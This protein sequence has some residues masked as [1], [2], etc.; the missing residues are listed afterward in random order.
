[1]EFGF[2]R[3][4]ANRQSM[5]RVFTALDRRRDAWNLQTVVLS[6]HGVKWRHSN[7]WS[8][9]NL[10]CG[11]V[12]RIWLSRV[13]RPHKTHYRS[14]RGGVIWVK[15][16]NEQCQSTEGSSGPKDQVSVPPGPPHHVTILKHAIYSDTQNTYI[17][18]NE[19]K[20]SEMGPVAYDKTQSRELLGMFVYACIALCTV[21][22]HNIAQNKPDNF[23]LNL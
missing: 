1:M 21:V 5:K 4:I 12:R 18:K 2:N 23:P 20:H 14:Y 3:S 6:R 16:P 13:Q 17:H 15:W 22:A 10:C 8:H 19:S 7:L 9:Y 11:A